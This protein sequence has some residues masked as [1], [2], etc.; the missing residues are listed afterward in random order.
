VVVAVDGLLG[1]LFIKGNGSELMILAPQ[2]EFE[3]LTDPF[4]RELLAHCYRMLGSIQDAEDQVQEAYLRA[5]RSFDQF[6]GRSS[7]RVWMYK[8]ATRVCLTALE[9]RSRRHLPSELQPPSQDPDQPLEVAEL[10]AQWVQP[11]P[12]SLIASPAFD[13]AA[14]HS[15]RAGIRLAFI[16]ALQTLT[17]RQRAVLILRDVLSMRAG[18]VAEILDTTSIAVN[19][20]LRRA[21]SQL[22]LSG[23][24]EDEV[25]EPREEVLRVAVDRYV[26]AFE[27]A[28][29][30]ALVGLLRTDVELEMPPTPTWFTGCDAV[31]GFFAARVM[32]KRNGWSLHP[33]R[34][35]GQVALAVYERLPDARLAAHGLHVL[36]FL[37]ERIARITVFND[38]SLMPTFGF[39]AVMP[40]SSDSAYPIREPG[41]RRSRGESG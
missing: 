8:I 17:A 31:S 26:D 16:A 23:V 13:P 4:R 11:I 32:A 20:A 22:Q 24:P 27:R 21:R 33:T 41:Q 40:G 3:T 39:A 25:L 28:D 18:E 34:A 15:S 29:V 38:S 1:H 2:G 37:G 19:S 9:S 36:T 7:L 12:D 35:N 6:E 5:W 10:G 30:D 14:R